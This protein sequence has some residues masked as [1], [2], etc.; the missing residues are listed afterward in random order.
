MQPTPTFHASD[1]SAW[2]AWLAENHATA[3]LIWLVYDKAHTSREGISYEESV[4]EALCFGWIDSLIKS[5]DDE[6]YARKFTPRRSGS[7]W[8]EANK[9]RVAKIIAE[10][11]MTAAG[12]AKIDYLLDETLPAKGT[13]ELL[14]PEWISLGLKQNA[15]AWENFSHLPPSHKKRYIAWLSSAKK[16]ETRQRNLEI[17]IQM[18]EQNIRLEMNTR[19]GTK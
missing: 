10:G 9:R 13:P 3:S 16:E 6:R 14:I 7:P 18:L 1:R 4:E 8:S 17:A 19:T 2:R 5:I 11:R 12:L 15:A